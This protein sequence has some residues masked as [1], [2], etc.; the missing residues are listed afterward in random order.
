MGSE[1]KIKAGGSNPLAWVIGVVARVT[2]A[3][4]GISLGMIVVCYC[5]EVAARYFFNSPTEWAHD[6]ASYLLCAMIFL[7]IP[8]ITR[9]SGHIA[10]TIL[11]D[12]LGHGWRN[13]V[14]RLTQLVSFAACGLACYISLTQN[15]KQFERGIQTLGTIPVPK[16][17]ISG[18]I[19][20]GLGLSALLFLLQ[21]CR[22]SDG[23]REAA[24]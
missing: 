10:I 20:I 5:Y 14:D 2:F 8:E 1:D 18:F 13:L 21:A 24:K 22:K 9:T 19:S 4:S 23:G 12:F 15:I 11:L 7:A 17:W 3:A 16:W 6:T